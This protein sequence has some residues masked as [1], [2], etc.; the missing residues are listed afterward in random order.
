MSLKTVHL[1]FVVCT[2]ALTVFLAVWNYIH[3][4]NF[5]NPTSLIYMIISIFCGLFCIVYG[6]K[7]LSKYKELGFM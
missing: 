7:F 2:T 1:F 4:K 6:K 5:D 3:W